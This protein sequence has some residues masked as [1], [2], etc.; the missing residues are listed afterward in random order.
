MTATDLEFRQA[1]RALRVTFADGAQ[2][3]IPYELLRVESPSAEV[4]GH[5]GTPKLV[6]GKEHVGVTDA[7][8]VG[9]YALRIVFDDGHA[10]GL[11]TWELLRR[12]GQDRD[13]LMSAYRARCAAR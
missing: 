5:G 11:Y 8:P 12:L 6:V 13:A 9:R 3:D 1:S 7:K 4:R 2:F 10:T